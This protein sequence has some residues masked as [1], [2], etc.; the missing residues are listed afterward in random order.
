MTP[1]S[2]PDYMEYI[3]RRRVR[4]IADK[5][6]GYYDPRQNSRYDVLPEDAA[7]LAT[8]L[9]ATGAEVRAN[10]EGGWDWRDPDGS[11]TR[12][13]SG[14]TLLLVA[15]ARADAPKARAA[16][17]RLLDS[18]LRR[19]G[20]L[21]GMLVHTA[22]EADAPEEEIAEATAFVAMIRPRAERQEEATADE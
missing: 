7:Q 17:L 6:P 15:S 11:V 18:L 14:L 12:G 4:E 20:D 8:Y 13:L 3:Q 2:N 1:A 19:A 9:A 16:D 22:L 10:P 5:Y 21:L